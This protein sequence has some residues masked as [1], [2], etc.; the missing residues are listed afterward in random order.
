MNEQVQNQVA[1]VAPV[2]K[3]INWKEKGQQAVAFANKAKDVVLEKMKKNK[4]ASVIGAVILSVG[5]WNTVPSGS[6]IPT[7]TGA[8]EGTNNK[9][10]VHQ[11]RKKGSFI[12]LSSR[13][14]DKVIL[15]NNH[16]DY[17]QATE[18][19]VIDLKDCPSLAALDTRALKGKQ[20]KYEGYFATYAGKPQV[21][22]KS[23]DDISFGK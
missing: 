22:V 12:I 13:K 10:V 17:K 6:H 5:L 7:A 16:T 8:V 23:A 18:T 3:N 20:V 4:I 2:A 21:L 11:E 19:V 14:T 9:Q 1:N 15:L